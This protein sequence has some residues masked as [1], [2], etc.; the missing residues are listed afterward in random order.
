MKKTLGSDHVWVA[1]TT[2]HL[3]N[4]IH[5]TEFRVFFVFILFIKIA[6]T[7][8]QLRKCSFIKSSSNEFF[9]LRTAGFAFCSLDRHF[10]FLGLC[11]SVTENSLCN[12]KPDKG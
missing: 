6:V 3:S 10:F 4:L 5:F 2:N 9:C 7:Y 12:L 8:F 1:T 11:F